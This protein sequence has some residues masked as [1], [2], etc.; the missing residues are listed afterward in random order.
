MNQPR[1]I[2]GIRMGAFRAG[3]LAA[4]AMLAMLGRPLAAQGPA[5][6]AP[7][8]VAAQSQAAVVNQSARR[9]PV[10]EE[11]DVVVV[12]GSTGAVA[13]AVAAAEA[14][15]EVFLL[16]P[17]PYL[18][19]DMT[20]TLRLWLEPGEVPRAPLAQR[21]FDDPGRGV[22]SPD[23]LRF[24]YQASLPSAGAHRDTDPPSL[25]CDGRFGDPASQSVQ[26]DG[27]VTIDADLGSL[28]PVREVRVVVYCRAGGTRPDGGFNVEQL[29]IS[30]SR[31]GE[32]WQEDAVLEGREPSGDY[33]VLAAPVGREARYVKISARKPRQLARILLGEI[34]ILGPMPEGA[35]PAAAPPRP[36]HVKKVLDEALLAAGVKYLYGCYATDVLR[37]AQG[38]PAG[39]VMANRAGRQAIV[40]RTIIDATERAWVARL[41][42]ARCRPYPAG[43]HHFKRVVIGGEA[44]SG[45]QLAA[46]IA[47]A[48][49]VGPYPNRAQTTSR[50]FPVIEYS[51][52]LFVA[53]DSH[54]AYMA[55][56]QQ[57]RTRTYHPEQQ[58]TSDRLFE[59]PPDAVFGRESATGPWQGADKLPLGAFQPE[60][61]DAVYVLGGCA[62]VSRPQAERLLRPLALME[63]GERIGRAAAAEAAARGTIQGPH[64][65]GA[66]AAHPAAAGDVR[67]SL[68]GLRPVDQCPTIEQP[69]TAVPVLGRYDVVVI[70][71]GTGGAPAGIGAARRG[72][73][74]LVVEYLYGLGGV[75][76]EGAIAGYYWG[77]RV[78][79]TASVQDGQT[80]WVVEQKKQWWR[81]ELLK[82]G[83]EIWF[84]TLGCGAFVENGRVKGAVVATPQG[85]G[86]VLAEVVIDAT[87]NADVAAAAGAETQY[88]DATEFGMQ[89][90]G[91]PGRRLGETYNNTDFTIVDETDML[92]IWRTFVFSKDK[93]PDAFDH[94]RLIDTRERR[95]IKGEATITLADQLLERTYPDTVVQAYSNFDTHGYTVDPLLLIEH[96]ERR[97]VLVNIP[98]RAMLPQG[99]EGMLVIGLAISAHRD[100]VP[101]IRMQPDIQ[102][103]GY[104]AGVAAAMA[105]AHDL[106]LRGIDIRAVQK[107]LVEIGNLKAEVLEQEDS[108]PLPQEKIA[109]AVSRIPEGSG[110]AVVMTHP[111]EALPM[112]R[113]AYEQA[114]GEAKLVYAKLLALLGDDAGTETLLAALRN[115]A[116]W[117]T[118]WDYRGMGQFGSAYSPMDQLIVA[119]GATRRK[120]A[121]PAILQKLRLLS[122]ADAFSHHRA[123][124][125]ALELIGDP[126]A[127]EPLAELLQKPGMAGHVQADIET[128]R[129]RGA[130]G[131]TNAVTGRRDSLRELLIARALYRCGDYQ[132]LG[133]KT[134]RAYTKDLRGHLARHAQAVLQ[135]NGQ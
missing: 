44:L 10:A 80:R 6:D 39:I 18:G 23:A 59:V 67:E 131:G 35:S 12:G 130:P 28:Q 55:A 74:T 77:N 87:G 5:A 69:A 9:I 76:T 47:A 83:A 133:R 107:H 84:G 103:G 41:A 65:P 13:A 128:A 43:V 95:R 104:A 121:L 14:G 26:Y 60:G 17:Y 90:T 15:A 125:R 19:E 2:G 89:G 119:L 91:L 100:A 63:L 109:E 75:G 45:E 111:Q 108:L 110:A 64:L 11:V 93:Y 78:G 29:A 94:G 129:Q 92:D 96:P 30:T 106:P 52:E 25:L 40:A 116:Q 1:K 124:A 22:P 4:G 135:E 21:I 24:T 98:Y 61:I 32:L 3:T 112:V 62:D 85:R 20:A 36:M 114:D 73:K 79:F 117:D 71:G 37:D 66:P 132:G 16:A 33:Y 81:S 99:L 115:T 122:A 105:A 31:D 56:D 97:G 68:Q 38:R 86:V 46:R 54:A 72:A 126:A 51:L 134:L 49:F 118:G 50:I 57:A 113:K 70:G 101:L 8:P 102:N 127:A 123:V 48:P 34:E 82:A 120:D 53:D 7:R 88:T 27:D 42:G 58:F